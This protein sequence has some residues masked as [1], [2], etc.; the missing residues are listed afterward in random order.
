M[1]NL[2]L[3]VSAKYANEAV[4][5]R[6]WLVSA[7]APCGD[8]RARGPAHTTFYG[9]EDEE[10]RCELNV[11]SVLAKLL[12][13]AAHTRVATGWVWAHCVSKNWMFAG[14]FSHQWA[15]RE[16]PPSSAAQPLL[17]Q[18][19]QRNLISASISSL[20]MFDPND[21]DTSRKIKIFKL[22]I[23]YFVINHKRVKCNMTM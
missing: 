3:N 15:W 22:C 10:R 4:S 8:L 9:S 7:H 21:G 14:C 23:E 18:H 17:L 6:V 2:N 5:A 12:H 20:H 13:S 11:H 1:L 16:V 19:L